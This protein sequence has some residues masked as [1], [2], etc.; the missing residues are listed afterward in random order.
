MPRW[1]GYFNELGSPAIKISVYGVAPAFQQEIEA[2]VDTGFT[3]FLS[4]PLVQAFPLGVVLVGTTPVAFADGSTSYRLTAWGT[5]AVGGQQESGI[6]MLE[7][8]SNEVLLGMEFIKAFQKTLLVSPG[9]R[10]VA[11]FD[12]EA[13][14]SVLQGP[15]QAR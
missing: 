15:E 8:D 5:A 4:V 2:V 11:L 7:P 10:L 13:M 1:T 6:I 9:N 14:L 3:G 12:D